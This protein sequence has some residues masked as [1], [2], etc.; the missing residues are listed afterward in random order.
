MQTQR[1]GNKDQ[2][3]LLP[4]AELASEIRIPLCARALQVRGGTAGAAEQELKLLELR[5][6]RLGTDASRAPHGSRGKP[7]SVA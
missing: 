5:L 6:R 1:R 4:S 3:Q 7:D 2:K